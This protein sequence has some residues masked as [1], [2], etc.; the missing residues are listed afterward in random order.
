[1]ELQTWRVIFC[2]KNPVLRNISDNFNVPFEKTND[3]S[4]GLVSEKRRSH[5]ENQ[6]PQDICGCCMLLTE[7][8][9]KNN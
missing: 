8:G 9:L 2:S 4:R 3:E 1:M 7:I 5:L 6:A